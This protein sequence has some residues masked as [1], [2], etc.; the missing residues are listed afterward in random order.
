MSRSQGFTLI[1]LLTVVALLALLAALAAPAMQRLLAAQRLRSVSYDLVSDLTLAR[2]EALKRGAQVRIA[3]PAANA[4]SQGWSITLV[5]DGTAFGQRKSLEGVT[6]TKA[7]AN[8]TFDIDGRTAAATSF[9]FSDGH[10]RYRCITLD[11]SGRPKSSTTA[12]P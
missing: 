7:P 3:P 6:V 9:G 10:G 2:S 5:S 11:P 12:C 4:W 1:E 8:L